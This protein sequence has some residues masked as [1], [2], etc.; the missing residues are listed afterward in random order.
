MAVASRKD[1]RLSK[2]K[3]RQLRIRAARKA[4]LTRLQL[5]RHYENLPDQA[6][7]FFEPFSPLFRRPTFLRFAILVVAALLTVGGRTVCNVLRTVGLLAPGDQSSYHRFF[8]ARRWSLIALGRQ[9]AGWIL[10]RLVP[11]GPVEL[12][13][14]RANLDS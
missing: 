5:R 10:D 12:A 13:L 8:S 3:R 11:V 4:R 9:L 6:R 2:S 14:N 1:S 7:S